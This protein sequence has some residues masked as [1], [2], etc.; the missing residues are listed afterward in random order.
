MPSE[1]V[2]QLLD[3]A[4][5][6]TPRPKVVTGTKSRKKKELGEEEAALVRERRASFR[7]GG[8]RLCPEDGT[9]CEF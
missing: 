7:G 3:P 8:R 9:M 6:C 5:P 2:Q 1:A 4:G